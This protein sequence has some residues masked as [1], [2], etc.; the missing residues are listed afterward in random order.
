VDDHDAGLPGQ[1]A[2]SRLGFFTYDGVN[3]TCKLQPDDDLVFTIPVS[4]PVLHQ[5]AFSAATTTRTAASVPMSQ[6]CDNRA[7]PLQHRQH[8]AMTTGPFRILA[9]LASVLLA[10]CQ[11]Q[12]SRTPVIDG[13]FELRILHINDQHSR[14]APDSGRELDLDGERVQVSFGG[15]PQLVTAF[16][17]LAAGAGHVLRLHAGDAITGDLYYTLF[18]GEADADLMNQVCFDAFVVGNHEF[19]FGDAGLK[20]FLDYLSKRTW[21]CHTPSLGANVVPALGVSPLARFSPSDYLLPAVTLERGGRRIGIV[22]ID[23]AGK[24]MAS[25][26]PDPGTVL[27]DEAEAAQGAID[28]LRADGVDIVILLTHI[29]YRSDLALATRLRGVDLIVGGDSHSLLGDEFRAFGLSP[30]GPY[31]TRLRNADGDP[32]CVVQAWQYTWAIGV[33]DVRFDADGRV[34]DCEGRSVI[35]LGD[36][37]RRDDQPLQ[38]DELQRALAAIEAS[39]NLVQFAPDPSA[40]RVLDFYRDGIG[41]F[42]DEVIAQVPERLCLRRAPGARDRSRDGAPGCAEATDAQG[43]LVQALVAE[44]FLSQGQRYGG[45]DIAL[46]NGGGVRNGIAQGPF[47]VGDAYLALPFKNT[48]VRLQLSGAELHQVLE[49]AIAFMLSDQSANTGAWPYAAGLRWRVDLTREAGQRVGDLQFRDGDAWVALDR[50]RVYR[51]IANDYIAGGRDGYASLA[52]VVGERRQDTFLDY[53]QALVDHAREVGELRR[54]LP[55][56]RSTQHLRD[57]DGR[58]FAAD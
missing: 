16:R 1:D 57:L 58:S 51:V 15:Y 6:R 48:L 3:P 28:A 50:E 38:G 2:Q 29:G 21:E 9:L 44:A 46:Q 49:E 47:T 45:A 36:D 55:A 19:D 27:V 20:R 40:Q 7:H 17:E 24:T 53:A 10:A 56:Q 11:H 26:S 12:P 33:L 52:D 43:G 14:L 37:L 32:V 23:V 5:C 13:P 8:P 4:S 22:G 34:V 42:A 54:P 25:S 35:L 31:P 18:Q 39:P 41:S 30:E